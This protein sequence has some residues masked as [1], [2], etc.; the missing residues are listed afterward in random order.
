MI[1]GAAQDW[2]APFSERSVNVS[3][4]SG[5]YRF[6]VRAISAD[7]TVSQTPAVVLFK[8]LRPVWQ[9]WWFITAACLLLALAA[10]TIYRYRVS[11][12]IELERVRTRIAT[13]LHDDIGAGLSQVAV[14]TEVL[15]RQIEP[16]DP[17]IAHNLSL[18][19]R[20]S[21]E[22]VDSMS[23]IVWAINPQKDNLHD[24]ARRMRRFAGETLAARDIEVHFRVPESEHYVK[25][26]ADV[27]RQVFLIF[28][29]TINNILRHADCTEAT[30]DLTIDGSW[31]ALS[32]SD[33]GK[34]I[35]RDRTFDGHG[36]A[37]IKQ[38]AERL[39]GYLE[40][41]S[42]ANRGTTVTLK[43]PHRLP[44]WS[45]VSAPRSDHKPT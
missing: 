37:S 1:E 41:D 17:R 21:R 8:I 23:D 18:I 31:L 26:G 33:N 3:L 9:R 2:S 15:R 6:L 16:A 22:V 20:V 42:P 5:T 28:K 14:I 29:E 19:A 43:I 32:V 4:G 38:R 30:I 40:I 35:I 25:L 12:L 39:G 34:G 7:G 36:L 11:R 24:L 13:D 27:R 10:Y 45:S 44:R